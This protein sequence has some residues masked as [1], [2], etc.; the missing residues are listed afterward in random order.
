MVVVIGLGVTVLHE[1]GDTE[2]DCGS[3]IQYSRCSA[4]ASVPV[5]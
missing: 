3:I 5:V 2:E 4:D 1:G